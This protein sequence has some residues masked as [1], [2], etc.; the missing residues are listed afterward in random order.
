[1]AS[2]DTAKMDLKDLLLREGIVPPDALN[3]ILREQEKGHEHLLDLLIRFGKFNEKKLVSL[4]SN[5]YGYTCINPSVFIIEPELIALVPKAAAEKFLALPITRLE[6]T[7]TVAVAN[8]TNLKAIDELRAITGMRIK[9]V[10]AEVRLLKKHIAKYYNQSASSPNLGEASES[11]DKQQLDDLVKMIEVEKETEDTNQ[12][13][14]L[15][16]AFETPVIKL[17]NMLLIEGIRR[18]ASDIFIEPWESFVRVRAR[19]DGLLE[20]IVRPQKVLGP[21]IVPALR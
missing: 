4:F 6:N 9:T 19:V 11:K 15:K 1:M 14:L 3:E 20:E 21:A 8:P 2:R 13:E 12:A 7:L 16:V 18:H 10:V 5:H 17:V